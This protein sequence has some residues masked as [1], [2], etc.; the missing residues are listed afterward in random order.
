M[1]SKLK[2]SILLLMVLL[3][4]GLSV[5]G[6]VK[7]PRLISDG[8]VLQRDAKVKI[9][10][11]AT[12]DEHVSVRFNH[13]DYQAT[14]DA[15]GNWSVILPALKAGG[16]FAMTINTVTIKNIMVGDVWICSGQSNMEFKMGWLSWVYETE[17]TNSE[18]LLIRQFEVPQKYDYNLPQNDLQSG[19]WQTANPKNILNFSAVAYFFAK[20]LSE[21]YHIAIGLIDA[22]VGGSPIEAWMSEGALKKFPGPYKE[23]NKFK[24]SSRIAQ[25]AELDN[26]RINLWYNQ[27]QQKDLGYKDALNPWFKPGA[28]LSD[29]ATTKVP[30]YWANGP[31]GA[32]NGVVWFRKSISIPASMIG[33]PAKLILGRIVDSDSTF[34]N[35]VLVGQTGY[36]YP[37]RRYD[38]P[39]DLL[40]EGENTIVV[41][42]INRTGKGGFVPDKPYELIC[43]EQTIDLK[44]D[45]KYQLGVK[46]EPLASQAFAN[47]YPVGLFNGMISPLLN[48]SIKGAIWYQGESN[49]GQ[50][51]EYGKLF[52]E[53]IMDWRNKWGQ[54]DFSFLFVQLPNI[55]EAK[56]EPAESSWAMTREA[57]LKTLSVPNTGMAVI[58]DIGE[59]NDP[60]PLNKK[61]VGKRLALSAQKVAYKEDVVYSGPIYQSMKIEGNKAILMFTNTGSGLVA[62]GGELKGFSMAGTDNHFIWAQA[63]IENNK[64]IVWSD[65]IQN[66]VSVRYAWADNPE[67]ANLFNKEGLPA[68]PFR[69]DK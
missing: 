11:W 8:M 66:P 55:M 62:K 4:S 47:R 59:W 2:Q 39:A 14:A 6:E 57:Q 64:I 12:K 30:G 3:A 45:W 50:P 19:T 42:V 65:K 40:K 29:W 31:L 7:L 68:S 18:N 69:T 38:V 49:A 41:R 60:H 10:G 16:P 35:G 61:D 21:K 46:M 51:L 33:K 53:M 13:G 36:Q 26:E 63:K 58:I 17:I 9:W 23:L 44:G 15:N 52:P 27:L 5:S 67:G 56:D 24:D 20:E 37:R 54:G 28:N 1:S 25:L 43:N 48:Y 34:I 22:S 32:I